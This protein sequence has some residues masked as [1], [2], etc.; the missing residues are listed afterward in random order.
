MGDVG[1]RGLWVAQQAFVRSILFS[2]GLSSILLGAALVPACATP[3]EESA[4]ENPSVDE[5][6]YTT[7]GTC[8]GLPKLKT[9]KTPPGVCVGLVAKGFTYARGIA[10]LPSG[11]FVLAEMGG[12]AQD[13]GAVWLLRKMPDK[14]FSKTRIAKLIDKPSGVAVGPDGLPYVGTPTGIFRFDPYEQTV[15]PVPRTGAF[16]SNDYKQ[17]RFKL[18]IKDLPGDGR[19]PLSRFVF[20]RKG[21]A[22][23]WTIF[24][25]LG[26]SSDVCEQGASARPPSGY[27]MPCPEAEGQNARGVIRKYALEGA[28]HV[29]SGFTV[30]ARGLRNSMALAIHPGSGALLQA[31]NA[32]DTINKNDAS[33]TDNEGELPHEE[34]NVIVPGSHYGWP[35]CYDNDAPSP[36]YRGRVDCSNYS[37][38]ALLLP[39]HVSPLGMTY[40]NGPMFPAPYK[41][42][43]IVT[44]HGYRAY[45]HRLV[46]VPVDANGVPGGGEPLDIIRGWD[47][48]A[49]GREPMGAPVDV[50]VAKDGSLYVTEDKNG[51]VLRVF[52][53]AAG[54]DG[55]PMRPVAPDA[56]SSNPDE[57]QRCAQLARRT[58]SFSAIQRDVIDTSCIGCHG[59]GPGY[60]GGLRLDKCDS[61]GN[62][63]RLRAARSGGRPAYVLP[64][65]PNQSELFLRLKGQGFPQMPA[66]GIDPEKVDQVEAWIAEGAPIPQ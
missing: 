46:M 23:E 37:K 2:L 11:D 22:D 8:D 27:P 32:R 35:Y 52:Y 38:P 24:A 17:P 26:S 62:G 44:Y 13:R 61:V 45:G 53:N 31:E 48:S 34:I 7:E 6:A 40:Y 21:T 50:H 29:A 36:E 59:V 47:K 63:Q 25:N 5:N 18:V 1:E 3:G 9:L 33:L 60:A 16:R 65:Q 20:G 15:D 49:D 30:I 39:G 4:E 28:D 14:S 64:N 42:N 19:H 12:W 58:D 41:G 56:P 57:A 66:G 10:E 43:L 51:T 54:G 55:A